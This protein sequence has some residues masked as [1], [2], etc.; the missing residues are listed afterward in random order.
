MITLSQIFLISIN[1]TILSVYFHLFQKMR[2]FQICI[3]EAF[4]QQC[5]PVGKYHQLNAYHMF[6]SLAK[7]LLVYTI[8]FEMIVRLIDRYLEDNATISRENI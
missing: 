5:I 1:M 8:P 7:L 6:L 3:G 2:S 4:T